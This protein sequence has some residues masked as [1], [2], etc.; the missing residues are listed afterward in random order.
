M[1]SERLGGTQTG[2]FSRGGHLALL[3][4]L[5]GVTISFLHYQLN[6]E[7]RRVESIRM[8]YM[9]VITNLAAPLLDHASRE[10]GDIRFDAVKFSSFAEMGEA[11]RNDRIQAAF[12][13]APLSVVLRQQ[14]EDVQVVYI[15]NRHESTLVVRKELNARSIEDLAGR[16]I[17]VPMRYSGHN[18]CLLRL[19]EEKS[20]LDRVRIVEMNPPDMAA[21][22]TAGSL[23]A[24]FVGEPFAAQSVK[25]G[26]AAPLFY[27]EEKWNHFICNLLLVKRRLIET[28]PDAVRRLV[29]AAIRSGKWASGHLDEAAEITVQY[30]NQPKELVVYALSTPP[31]RVSFD[32]YLP[33]PE[34]MREIANLMKHFRLIS[35]D[36]TE[37]LVEPRFAESVDF[38]G[39]TTIESVI[40]PD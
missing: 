3:A 38:S 16:T 17:A 13:I 4:L 12:V 35:S 24:Y 11:L 39:I 33:K 40:P 34:E 26:V 32:Q 19:L 29:H 1:P 7:K 27:V 37:G 6:G 23:D 10:R 20:L 14:G 9:P 2:R 18:L 15:G 30:W 28:N 21:A 22:L 5:W 31:N 25:S 36:T 8:G